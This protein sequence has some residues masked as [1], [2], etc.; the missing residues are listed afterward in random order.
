MA[1]AAR[2]A[3]ML[4]SLR[5]PSSSRRFSSSEAMAMKPSG[6]LCMLSGTAKNELNG[7]VTPP[8]KKERASSPWTS[9][10]PAPSRPSTAVGSISPMSRPPVGG[11]RPMPQVAH[12]FVVTTGA[13]GEP[14]AHQIG[15][16]LAQTAVDHGLH[17]LIERQARAD[18][19]ADFVEAQRLAQADVLGLH[20]LLL[21]GTNHH[22]Q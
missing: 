11:G 12:P 9:T 18:R 7:A 8:S 3:M 16:E 13:V 19:L 20:P 6:R 21:D 1:A 4:R 2:E 17:H 22:V 5:S 14:G 10:G 15:I